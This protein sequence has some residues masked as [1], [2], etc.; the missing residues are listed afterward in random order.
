MN[1]LRTIRQMM[2]R[3]KIRQ[4]ITSHLSDLG[5][6]RLGKKK[7]HARKRIKLFRYLT[8]KEFGVKTSNNE[9]RRVVRKML[10]GLRPIT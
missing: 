8:L 3:R 1:L 10:Q 2:V 7:K 9:V 6:K 5:L 4:I